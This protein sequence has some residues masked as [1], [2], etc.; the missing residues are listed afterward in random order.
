MEVILNSTQKNSPKNAFLEKLTYD[1]LTNS[2]N[3]EHLDFPLS[4]IELPRLRDEILTIKH[5]IS[6]GKVGSV[7]VKVD[8]GE[9][10]WLSFHYEFKTF[11]AEKIISCI[12]TYA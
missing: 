11:K 2:V 5:G 4:D 10:E 12:V 8:N 7:L 9:L 3:E 1:I 6:H